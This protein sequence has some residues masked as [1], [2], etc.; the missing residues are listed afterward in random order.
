MGISNQNL[1]MARADLVTH[2][3]LNCYFLFWVS[4]LNIKFLMVNFGTFPKSLCLFFGGSV[5]CTSSNTLFRSHSRHCQFEEQSTTTWNWNSHS[6]TDNF[7]V[8]LQNISTFTL[9]ICS[10]ESW[11]ISMYRW[12][13]ID[14]GPQLVHNWDYQTHLN[15]LRLRS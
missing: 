13:Y 2:F 4:L 5:D 3:A 9:T 14:W 8:Q 11:R 7:S 15:C 12:V 10:K 1:N 6:G